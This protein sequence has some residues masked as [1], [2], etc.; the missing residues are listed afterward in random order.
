M[1]RKTKLE[2]SKAEAVYPDTIMNADQACNEFR[3]SGT[4]RMHVL[5]KFR[6]ISHSV[7]DWT[8]IFHDQRIT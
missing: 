2:K 4:T 3:L 5:K 1:E 8:R 7:N 6:A